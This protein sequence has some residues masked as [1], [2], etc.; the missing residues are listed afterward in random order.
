MIVCAAA[1]EDVKW[2]ESLIVAVG[3]T[4]FCSVPVPVW[5]E[6]A[7]PALAS[8]LVIGHKHHV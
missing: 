8:V 5:L 7:V 2:R 4:A 1:A 3:V 6:P